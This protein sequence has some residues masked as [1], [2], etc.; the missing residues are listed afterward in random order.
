MPKKPQ[1][2]TPL[3]DAYVRLGNLYYFPIGEQPDIPIKEVLKALQES[4]TDEEYFERIKQ[5]RL[6]DNER[7]Y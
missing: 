3:E 1:P 6:Y 4:K 7:G 2:T 5:I